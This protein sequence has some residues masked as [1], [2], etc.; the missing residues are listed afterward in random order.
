LELT[1]NTGEHVN[2]STQ[3][4][5]YGVIIELLR[6]KRP[7]LFGAGGSAPIQQSVFTASVAGSPSIGSS[8]PISSEPKTFQRNI[9]RIY[10]ILFILVPFLFLFVWFAITNPETRTTFLIV[11]VASSLLMLIPFFQVNM[12]KV[13]PNKLTIET[14][15]EQKEFSARQIKEIKMQAVTG[16]YG[17][18]TNF[19][20][21][22][23]IEGKKYPLGGFPEGEE[24]IYGYLMN[25]WNTY[26]NK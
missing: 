18:V 13:E 2:V 22:V 9:F 19:V 15:F 11:A 20:H 12:I 8:Q 17:R 26:Q 14:F 21:I 16:R 4:K 10:G 24:I 7:D 23:P 6:Q 1:S 3:L 25:W 5:G